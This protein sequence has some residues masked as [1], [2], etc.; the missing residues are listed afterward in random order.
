[1]V[2]TAA[3]AEMNADQVRYADLGEKMVDNAL[4]YKRGTSQEK[5]NAG[6]LFFFIS[7]NLCSPQAKEQSHGSR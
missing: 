5:Y 1:M 4:L 6:Y 7:S 3:M 2:Y